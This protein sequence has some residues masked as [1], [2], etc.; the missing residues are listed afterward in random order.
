M[1]HIT[2]LRVYSS[3]MLRGECDLVKSVRTWGLVTHWNI[4]QHRAECSEAEMHKE[5]CNLFKAARVQPGVRFCKFSNL[6]VFLQFCSFVLSD[7]LLLQPEA[8]FC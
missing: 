7:S 5:E 3:T 6:L 2:W 8:R 1:C 4:S